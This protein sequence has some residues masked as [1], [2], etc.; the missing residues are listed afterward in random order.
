[1]ARRTDAV[2]R[3]TGMITGLA[4]RIILIAVLVFLL[5]RGVTIA[6]SIGH[7]LL[8]E[9]GMEAAPG[10]AKTLVIET[11]DTSGKIAD[12]LLENGLIDNKA[13]FVLQSVLYQASFEPGSYEL[14]TSM[15]IED[16]LIYLSDEA[17]KQ[18]ELKSKNLVSG[19]AEETTEADE[20]PPTEMDHMAA[21]EATEEETARD[22]A[23]SVE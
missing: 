3:V 22:G 15:T 1:M 12:K 8:Y 7:G 19:T 18:Q 14:N 5:V 13:A 20:V 10:T 23:A 11:G 2:S 9:H 21:D 17:A 16:M 4:G 6:Y